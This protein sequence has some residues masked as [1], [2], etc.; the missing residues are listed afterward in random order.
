MRWMDRRR[1]K[2]GDWTPMEIA[3]LN[4]SL[5]HSHKTAH[6]RAFRRLG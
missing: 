2:H 5:V 1:P 6:A 3:L 4:A